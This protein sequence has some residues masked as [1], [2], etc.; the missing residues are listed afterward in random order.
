MSDNIPP[1]AYKYL[2]DMQVM[3]RLTLAKT[4]WSIRAIAD[5][6][7]CSKTTVRLSRGSQA[8]AVA[9]QNSHGIELLQAKENLCA[10]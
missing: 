4:G 10:V 8:R 5:E 1:S 7:G 2:T 9:T 6:I 3:Q